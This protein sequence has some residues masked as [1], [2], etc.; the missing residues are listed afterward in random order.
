DACDRVPLL[1]RAERQPEQRAR[2]QSSSVSGASR[3]DSGVSGGGGNAVEDLRQ[4]DPP[5][6]PPPAGRGGNTGTPTVREG[7]KRRTRSLTLA[8]HQKQ[9]PPPCREGAGMGPASKTPPP[10]PSL[11]GGGW[12]WVRFA[13]S[14]TAL[15]TGPC[16]SLSPYGRIGLPF[17]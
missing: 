13:K 9:T 10:A 5:P 2:R 14:F 16:Y 6:R 17:S 15:P 4:T 8:V 11:Q 12:G 7:V 1:R 3:R